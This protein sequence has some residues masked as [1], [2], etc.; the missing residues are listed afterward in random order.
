MP[1]HIGWLWIL[2]FFSLLATADGQ[3]A[4][5]PT[6]G[7]KFDGTYAFVSRTKVNK[8]YA[9]PGS[10]RIGQCGGSGK[11][12]H[13]RPLTFANGHAQYTTAN[14]FQYEG[15]VSSQGEVAMRSATS[16]S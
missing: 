1:Q 8:T 15:T 12:N 2:V 7:T 3:T 9:V 14:G 11:G 16:S 4:S 6:A 10:N 5:P 13:R